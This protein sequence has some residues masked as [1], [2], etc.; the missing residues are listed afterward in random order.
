MSAREIT[1]WV[2]LVALCV[3]GS[4]RALWTPDEPREAEII[5][6][7]ALSPG[8]IPQLNGV[9][10]HEK[11]PL[12]YWAG[13]L[14][15]RCTGSHSPTA[16]RSVSVI[17]SL[18]TLLALYLWG[19]QAAGPR[20]AL[21]AIM[22]LGGCAEF[23]VSAHWIRIDPLLMFFCTLAL[24]GAWQLLVATRGIG[25][26][27]LTYS[28][29]ILALW[30]KGLVGPVTVLA[31]LG[32]YC[33]LNWRERPWRTLR[34]L[35]GASVLLGG[36]LLLAGLIYLEGGVH[37]LKAWGW[38]NHVL[39]FIDPQETGHRQPVYYYLSRLPI[40]LI[41][42]LVALLYL[43]RRDFWRSQ[44]ALGTK[45]FC[46]AVTLGA[47]AI[48]SAA[49]TKREIYLL[50]ILP[51]LSL[52]LAL[53]ID[54]WRESLRSLA[55]QDS[56]GVR[57]AA[58][59]QNGLLL[60]WGLV[61]G[62]ALLVYGA[63]ER[64]EAIAS[65][66]LALGLALVAG[67]GLATRRLEWSAMAGFASVSLAAL[68]LL[69]LIVP[70]VNEQKDFTPFVTELD[71]LLPAGA[72]VMAV[73]ADETVRGIV[74]F[75]TGRELRT[76]AA[77]ALEESGR[78]FGH[79]KAPTFLLW[80]NKSR[81]E[82]TPAPAGYDLVLDHTIGHSRRLM[83]WRRKATP[84]KPLPPRRHRIRDRNEAPRPEE[85]RDEAFCR[86]PEKPLAFRRRD[87]AHPLDIDHEFHA[88]RAVL[89]R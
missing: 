10:F 13:A 34:P 81:H 37:A 5:R 43:F 67:W 19:R 45:R 39:R 63:P 2:V 6:E 60:L 82:S 11:P 8:M 70:I 30:T 56:R 54:H 57:L 22:I 20:V 15:F 44:R 51:I 35:T 9:P 89:S 42:W 24:W 76:L 29:L 40:T 74:P 59:L 85:K 84:P 48:L 25:A 58:H 41:P 33:L 28:G 49:S 61:P 7:M 80:Q 3:I 27:V 1:V 21:L 78:G 53:V 31:G 17:F 4:G 68:C 72:P 36:L 14:I 32:V 23:L 18:L 71:Q 79:E 62:T 75:L 88:A 55:P 66:L 52:L 83:L 86:L 65:I 46:L 50:P 69:L 16:A 64:A 12:Y 38:D 47:L 87:N 26:L 73:G 77:S